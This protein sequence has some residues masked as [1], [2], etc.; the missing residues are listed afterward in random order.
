[1]RVHNVDVPD[2]WSDGG[3]CRCGLYLS[4]AEVSTHAYGVCWGGKYMVH[5][6]SRISGGVGLGRPHKGR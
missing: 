5:E 1:M 4:R 3:W 2:R 6:R